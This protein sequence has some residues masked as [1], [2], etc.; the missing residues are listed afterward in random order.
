MAIPDF[1]TLMFPTLNY[2]SDNRE[3]TFRESIDYL[4][5]K[6]GLTEEERKELTPSGEMRLLNTRVGWT[7]SYLKKAGLLESTRRGYYKITQE[8]LETLAQKPDKIDTKYLQRFT[9]FQE[10]LNKSKG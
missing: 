2:A 9:R 3:H 4:A 5:Q 1:E 7:L 8:G 6:F 10:F